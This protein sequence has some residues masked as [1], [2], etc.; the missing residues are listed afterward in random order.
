M[1]AAIRSRLIHIRPREA[2]GRAGV[3]PLGLADGYRPPRKDARPYALLRGQKVPI[4]RVSLE[5]IVLDLE[6][7]PGAEIGDQVTLLGDCG[8]ER[9]TLHD[10]SLWLGAAPHEVLMGFEGRLRAR[11]REDG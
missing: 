9:I 1:A 3:I 7:F 4:A 2:N 11:Y 8:N 5:Y 10:L 6:R